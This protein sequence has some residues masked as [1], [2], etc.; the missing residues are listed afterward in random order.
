ML[1]EHNWQSL[2][3]RRRHARL[4]MFYKIHFQ[5]VPICMPLIPKH[6]LQPTVRILKIRLP[7]I[8]SSACN[9]HLQSFYPRSLLLETIRILCRRQLFNWAKAFRVQTCPPRQL[10]YVVMLQQVQVK[11]CSSLHTCV[12]E[13]P[14]PACSPALLVNL[15]HLR[16]VA[17]LQSLESLTYWSLCIIIK[18]K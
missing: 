13:Q 11:N 18:K 1:S 12:W 3:E 7:M 2:A 16:S 5:L 9:Y 17:S 15:L 10:D 8:P 14:A 6:Y 4:V